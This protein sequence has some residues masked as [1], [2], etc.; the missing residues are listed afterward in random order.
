MA[1][2]KPTVEFTTD[3]RGELDEVRL[4][5]IPGMGQIQ[6]EPSL[7]YVQMLKN[8]CSDVNRHL[9]DNVVQT[10]PKRADAGSKV[11]EHKVSLSLTHPSKFEVSE[12]KM[13]VAKTA[14]AAVLKPKAA[15]QPKEEEVTNLSVKM[16]R[17]QTKRSTL[18]LI[19]DRVREHEETLLQQQFLKQKP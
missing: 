8:T 12:E 17:N 13:M 15:A 19:Q 2:K 11:T 9:R 14:Q 7:D 3:G 4:Y 1:I 16:E 5:N 18:H 6:E 10:K